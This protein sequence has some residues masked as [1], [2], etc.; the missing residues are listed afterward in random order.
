MKIQNSCFPNLLRRRLGSLVLLCLVTS[1]ASAQLMVD[2]SRAPDNE[3]LQEGW[4]P[5][6]GDGTN[7]FT[8]SIDFNGTSI[9]VTIEG[10]T[11]WR[12]YREA[13]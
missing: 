11:H 1:T 2:F 6:Q 9:D 12:D 3:P 10:N 8:E 4:E 13:T 5:F 7:F